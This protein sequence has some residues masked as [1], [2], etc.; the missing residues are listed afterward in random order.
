MKGYKIFT[1]EKRTSKWNS[2]YYDI[3]EDWV[4]E[5]GEILQAK[6]FD[7]RIE[8]AC[9]KGVNFWVSKK[10]AYDEFYY[11]ASNDYE[12][13]MF[14]VEALSEEEGDVVR[15]VDMCQTNHLSRIV[16]S[17]KHCIRHNKARAQTLQLLKCVKHYKRRN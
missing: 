10:V 9:G 12:V 3:K 11:F 2:P 7:P 1:K 8:V 17:P 4:I 5:E 13:K 15:P 14:R 16:K 6:D